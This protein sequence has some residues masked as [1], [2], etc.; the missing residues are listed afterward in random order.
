MPSNSTACAP[1]SRLQKEKLVLHSLHTE[2]PAGRTLNS[3][4]NLCRPSV[5]TCYHSH[6]LSEPNQ[7]YTLP[8]TLRWHLLSTS[9]LLR[10]LSCFLHNAKRLQQ[11]KQRHH[12]S[13]VN[14]INC[15]QSST[16]VRTHTQLVPGVAACMLLRAHMSVHRASKDWLV[17]LCTV[18]ATSRI[19]L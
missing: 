19:Q 9:T 4:H 2:Q 16:C 14:I 18:I 17:K 6:S 3:Q 11:A 13:G 7:Y 1:T 15:H 8:H 10:P 5:A 12:C